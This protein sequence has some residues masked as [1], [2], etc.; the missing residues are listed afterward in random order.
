[1]NKLLFC[2]VR[3]MI[4]VLFKL[5]VA[6]LNESAS[7]KKSERMLIVSGFIPKYDKV[8]TFLNMGCAKALG[9]T[10]NRMGNC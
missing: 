1:M 6:I 8:F 5:I 7:N 4:L 3:Y 2:Y 10:D 9:N